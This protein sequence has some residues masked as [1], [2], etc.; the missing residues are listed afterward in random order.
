MLNLQLSVVIVNYKVKY[1]LEQC[2]YAV[3]RATEGI[4]AEVFVVD[5]ASNDGS[6]AFFKDRF[7]GVHFLWNKQNTGFAKANN[8][9]LN[10]LTGKTTLFLNPD[11][12]VGEDS[13]IRCLDF[14]ESHSDCGALG[15][16]MI[17]G[18]GNFLKESKRGNPTPA[19]SFYKISGLTALFPKS[20]VF[21]AYYASHL[22]G[23]ATSE[24]EVLPGAYLMVQ[25]AILKQTGGFD[26]RFFMYA[27]D[28]DLSLQI[29]QAGYRNYYF[30]EVEIIH[31]KGE[32]TQ[33]KSRQYYQRFYGAMRLFAQKHYATKPFSVFL[34]SMAIRGA[35]F[36]NHFGNL[37]SSVPIIDKKNS[38]LQAAIVG[39]SHAFNEVLQLIKLAAQPFQVM[40]RVSINTADDDPASV[41]LENLIP[42]LAGKPVNCI[43]F[44]LGDLDYRT[45]ITIM[46]NAGTHYSYFFHAI[47]SHSI[48]GSA[49]KGLNGMQI[50][51]QE[52]NL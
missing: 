29:R 23:N 40:G 46:K 17:D 26:E 47:G 36:F 5:N 50:A 44:C 31:F 32:S 41:D 10:L 38:P 28:I 39:N 6:A 13:F 16:K 45:A 12:I 42:W 9:V 35:Q 4:D 34:M 25:T 22:D 3:L 20:P 15:V 33:K 19:N 48:V 1:F 49:D 18:S 8:Q 24:V 11:T 21:A 30:P 51:K 43:V 7:P 2:L 14:F 37:F 27:E 52:V